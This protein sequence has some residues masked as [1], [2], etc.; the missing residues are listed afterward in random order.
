MPWHPASPSW[1]PTLPLSAAHPHSRPVAWAPPSAQACPV[2][3]EELPRDLHPT[4]CFQP[5]STDTSNTKTCLSSRS[6]LCP[7]CDLIL[8]GLLWAEHV[9][10]E[11]WELLLVAM[12]GN[13]LA[14]EGSSS[15]REQVV[16]FPEETDAANSVD[17]A[18]PGVKSSKSTTPA[19]SLMLV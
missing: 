13:S 2:C 12:G 16:N 3:G 17:R 15:R 7:R 18:N 10:S 4:S 9:A 19:F 8:T 1:A 6:S 11:A 14:R 5:S